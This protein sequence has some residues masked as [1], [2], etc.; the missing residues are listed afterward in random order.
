MLEGVCG[1]LLAEGGYAG[2]ARVVARM[3]RVT[4]EGVWLDLMTMREPY[5][6]DGAL[7]TVMACATAVFPGHFTPEGL[8]EE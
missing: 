5:A 4:V 6:R 7:R 3:L 1:R 8:G 2:E